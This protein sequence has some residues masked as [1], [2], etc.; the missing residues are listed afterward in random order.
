[1]IPSQITSTD[2]TEP[3]RDVKKYWM[4]WALAFSLV[5][6]VGTALIIII[7]SGSSTGKKSSTT[8]IIEDI[9]LTPSITA[10]APPPAI[11]VPSVPSPSTPASPATAPSTDAE[12]AAQIPESKQLSAPS[13]ISEK[14]GG[15]ISTPLGL[16]MTYGYFSGIADGKTLRDDIRSYY[17]EIVEKINREW[18]SKAVQLNEPLH[19]DGIFELLVQHDGTIVSIR[20]IQGTGSREAD[21][22][23]TEIIRSASPLP[24]L[25]DSYD[26]DLFMAPLRIKAPSFLFRLGN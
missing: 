10:P 13:G 15:L 18:W 21:Q 26:Q 22:L 25:P 23:V 24:S 7:A 16:G 1:M 19:Q 5:L 3:A 12:K 11:P 17:F 2:V 20:I 14:K 9:T 8:F 6:H 4:Q